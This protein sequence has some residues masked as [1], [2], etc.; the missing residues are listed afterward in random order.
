MKTHI[1]VTALITILAASAAFALN[2][3]AVPARTG[4]IGVL[5]I[6]DQ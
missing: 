3:P 4:E 2:A 6:P 5:R 1:A